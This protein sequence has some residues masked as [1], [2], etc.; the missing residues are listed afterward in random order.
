MNSFE[1]NLNGIQKRSKGQRQSIYLYPED[2][3]D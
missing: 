2:Y 3:T 1:V